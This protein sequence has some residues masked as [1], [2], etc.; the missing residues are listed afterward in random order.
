MVK[1]KCNYLMIW[2][3]MNSTYIVDLK[4]DLTQ[5]KHAEKCVLRIR[6]GVPNLEMKIF[7]TWD[8]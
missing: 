1:S 5:T 2:F 7:D 4:A 8:C 6:G 3:S